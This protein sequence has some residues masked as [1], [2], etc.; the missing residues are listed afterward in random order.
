MARVSLSAKAART[1][2][3]A[4]PRFPNASEARAWDELNAALAPKPR[5]SAVRK[6]ESRK[7]SKAAETKVLRG[8]VF[9]RSRGLC[10]AC[11]VR[12]DSYLRRDEWDHFFG[13]AKVRQSV[14]STW[15][16]CANCHREKTRNV[17]NASEWLCL[18]ALHCDR[19]GYAPEASKARARL[20][21]LRLSRGES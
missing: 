16:L 1:I 4:A 13:K 17:P 21:A 7:R 14:A 12:F 18:F 15:M 19:H 11:G 2:S 6:T 9:V 10:E 8:E 5:S 3:E 20:D